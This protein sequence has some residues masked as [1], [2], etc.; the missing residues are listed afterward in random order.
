MP[1]PIGPIRR[2]HLACQFAFEESRLIQVVSYIAINQESQ[3]E[4]HWTPWPSAV[5]YMELLKNH[6]LHNSIIHWN[7]SRIPGGDPLEPP[8]TFGGVIY[9]TFEES[10][11]ERRSGKA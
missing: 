7:K 10:C 11:K 6:D 5:L 4:T 1:Y 8:V 2:L 3:G 9:R